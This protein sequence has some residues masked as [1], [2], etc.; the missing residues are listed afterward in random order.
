MLSHHFSQLTKPTR[1]VILGA[2]GFV[3]AAVVEALEKHDVDVLR[4]GRSDVDL[5]TSDA[6]DRLVAVLRREDAVVLVSAVAPVKNYTMLMDNLTMLRPVVAALDQVPPSHLVYISSDAVYND[7]SEPLTE[8]SCADPGS[9]H[10]MMHRARELVLEHEVADP[11]GIPMASLRPTL[12]YGAAD[13][14]NGY[15]PNRFRRLA[16]EG[17]NVVLFGEGEERRDHVDVADVGDLAA[18]MVLR[19]SAGILNAATGVVTSFRDVAEMIVA[20]FDGSVVV[21]GSPRV[22]PMP[23]NGFRA[24]DPSSTKRAFPEFRYTLLAEGLGRAHREAAEAV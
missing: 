16:A 14:H 19:R 15:G 8:I 22:G 20:Q 24:F 4:L 2:S 10:G 23:H 7:S 18:R 1:A 6:A 17:R 21:E 9:L 3:G 12:I 13:P 5:L 11:L